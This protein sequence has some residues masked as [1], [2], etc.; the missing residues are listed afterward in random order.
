M[1]VMHTRAPMLK[2]LSTFALRDGRPALIFPHSQK[3]ILIQL[4]GSPPSG[5]ASQPPSSASQ[6]TPPPASA[7]TACSPSTSSQNPP[8]ASSPPG[9]PSAP[10][11]WP[12]ASRAS[13]ATRRRSSSSACAPT[14][15]SRLRSGRTTRTPSADYGA[16]HG[17]RGWGPLRAGWAPRLCG[18]CL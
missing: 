11:A 17:T 18:V 4:Q 2:T 3:Q 12:A 16:S 8:P 5:P 7:S 13:S 1:Q 9:P 14:A 6:P 15:P 10:R